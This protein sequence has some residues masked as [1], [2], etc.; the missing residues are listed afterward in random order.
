[1]NR[2]ERRRLK[3]LSRRNAGVNSSANETSPGRFPLPHFP[4]IKILE[5]AV[6]LHAQGSVEEAQALLR[7]ILL[8]DPAHAG[9]LNVLGIVDCQQ[10]RLEQGETAP[11]KF[12]RYTR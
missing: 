3:K 6:T 4:T 1:M 8:R 7:D 2:K 11:P 5:K 9:A 12:S 10:G